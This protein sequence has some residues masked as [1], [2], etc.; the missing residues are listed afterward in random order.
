MKK[1]SI[2]LI[3]FLSTFIAWKPANSLD[4]L[5]NSTKSHLNAPKLVSQNVMRQKQFDKRNFPVELQSCQRAKTGV[6]CS[7]LITNTGKE[8]M[9]IILGD[10]FDHGNN[11]AFDSSGEIFK[12]KEM[13]IGKE[14][15]RSLPRLFAVVTIASTLIRDIPTKFKI[16]FDIPPS[17]KS[18][19][20]LSVEYSTRGT[21][22]ELK[23]VIVFRDVSIVNSTNK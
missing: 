21:S 14:T 15:T 18:F 10:T 23:S 4:S 8:N 16:F 17:L 6:V 11:Q 1:Q 9:R 12:A 22:D 5:F 19:S 3:A 7:V 13:Q 2:L 20:A